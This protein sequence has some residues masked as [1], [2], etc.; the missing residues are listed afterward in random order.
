MNF[1]S[2]KTKNFTFFLFFLSACT[3]FNFVLDRL[4]LGKNK[5]LYI[6]LV[7]PLGLHY[8]CSRNMRNEGSGMDKCA[9]ILFFRVTR[10]IR[11]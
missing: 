11:K 10:D 8:L 3:T 1:A 5:K 2:G 6:F 7:F 4:R 9:G